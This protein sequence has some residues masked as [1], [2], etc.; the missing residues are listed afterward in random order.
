L[1]TLLCL[2]STFLNLPFRQSAFG[3]NRFEWARSEG[4]FHG[5]KQGTT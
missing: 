5:S 3:I 1:K 4:K 2:A